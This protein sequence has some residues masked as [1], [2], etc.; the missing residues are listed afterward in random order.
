MSTNESVLLM[1]EII[2]QYDNNPKWRDAP[3]GDVKRLSNTH[4]GD[5]GQD[6]VREWCAIHGLTWIGADGRHS[7]WDA[8]IEGFTFE[9]K[10][11]TED[12]S[13]GFQFNHV[14]HH[15]EYQGLLC[16]GISPD[17]IVFDAWTKGDVAE[18][19]AG[20]LV[21]MDRGSSATFKLSKRRESLRSIDEF[22]ERILEV[23]NQGTRKL[24]LEETQ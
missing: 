1:Q 12:V 10:T 6:F 5:I 14:R 9:V 3:L 23:I 24:D 22:K 4:I 8:K 16:I 13:G 19:R 20:K 18:S 2:A 21:T 7:P 17:A 11:A 15:R